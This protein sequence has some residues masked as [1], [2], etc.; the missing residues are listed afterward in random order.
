[1]DPKKPNLK[2]LQVY[3]RRSLSHPSLQDDPILECG[4]EV[5]ASLPQSPSE[6]RKLADEKL[7][8]FPFKDVRICWRRLYTDASLWE[9]VQLE[10]E[11]DWP[12]TVVKTL[13]MALI[14]TGAPLRQDL[15]EKS[16]EILGDVLDKDDSKAENAVATIH[17]ES[18]EDTRP[19]PKRRKLDR[20]VPTSFPKTSVQI[21][22]HLHP[23]PRLDNPSLSAFQT[24]L[25]NDHQS[26]HS[27]GALPL[28]IT[29]ALTHWP[30][31]DAS[32]S[33]SWNSPDYLLKKTLGGRR[34]VPIE[35]GRSYT[36]ESWG[37]RII[38]FGDFVEK[39]M[40]ECREEKG[41]TTE[42][43]REETQIGYLAQHDLFAQIPSLRNDIAIP[44]Y[45]Y[46]VP[47][48][49][50]LSPLHSL[51]PSSAQ[52]PIPN[53]EEHETADS[54]IL[55]NAWFGPANTTSPL[56][57][58]PHH[59]I[60]AQAVGRKYV[61]LYPSS[62]SPF[63]YPRGV[64]EDTGVDESNTSQIDIEIV[65]RYFEGR[66]FGTLDGKNEMEDQKD[67]REDG[68]GEEVARARKWAFEQEFPEFSEARYLEG[69]LEAGECLFI[70]KGW[71]HYIRSLS[72][73][74]S[75]SFWWD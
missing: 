4:T 8:V 58:D 24:R 64:N 10:E 46:S 67:K 45:C 1:M 48:A 50:T 26:N 21:P 71:W 62:Q 75:V 66:R 54:Q 16:F 53:D 60:L 7:H 59:N 14:M 11:G 73:S 52:S 44:D 15:I 32:S 36:D 18:N 43:D 72:P 74:F 17:A 30:A 42:L 63:L 29:G 25:N 3:I 56:H 55:L 22:S 37:Q 34:L 9:I 51:E 68:E 70:P 65:M 38:T 47:P 5:L 35:I 33:R 20:S 57:T 23:L 69:V 12:T 40:L 61:R 39:Y 6:A 27:L 28:I 19:T 49:P 41:E 31:L 13:D 2:T